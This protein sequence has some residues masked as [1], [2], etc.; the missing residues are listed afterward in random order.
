M[1][2]SYI[3]SFSFFGGTA[4]PTDNRQGSGRD[5]ALPPVAVLRSAAQERVAARRERGMEQEV[6]PPVF[7]CGSGRPE[8]EEAKP[9]TVGAS[10][11]VRGCL[12]SPP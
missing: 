6:L 7:S 12:C 10:G 5:A 2:I 9:V 4:T 8:S 1:I 3:F 11:P